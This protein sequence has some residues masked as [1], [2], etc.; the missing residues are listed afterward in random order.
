M[1]QTTAPPSSYKGTPPPSPHPAPP[2]EVSSQTQVGKL[3]W[4]RGSSQAHKVN[5]G[6]DGGELRVERGPARGGRGTRG[7]ATDRRK[8]PRLTPPPRKSDTKIFLTCHTRW[9]GNSKQPHARH[10]TT[11]KATAVRSRPV[12]RG[13]DAAAMTFSCQLGLSKGQST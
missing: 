4:K 11:T 12:R 5:K 13:R 9:A 6:M 1:L 3:T 8:D 7:G 2:Q 10:T